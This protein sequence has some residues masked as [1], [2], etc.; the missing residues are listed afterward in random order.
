M[1]VNVKRIKQSER[2]RQTLDRLVTTRKIVERQQPKDY[3][4]CVVMKPWG[5][6]Y[7]I[8]EN[9]HVAIWFLKIKGRHST[10]MHCHPLKRTSLVLLSGKA[11]CNTLQHRNYLTSPAGLIIEKS[12]FHST[13]ALSS[14]G[15]ELIEIESPPNK[16]D[17]VRLNDTYGREYHGYEGFSEMETNDLKRFNYFHF[18]ESAEPKELSHFAEDYAI[19]F[20]TYTDDHQF[21]NDFRPDENEIVSP[22]RGQ[23]IDESGNPLL[24]AGEIQSGQTLKN[25]TK[26][27]TK[28]RLSL[29][30]IKGRSQKARS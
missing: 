13:K 7:L 15:I 8:F 11:F 9:E 21:Q 1:D 3:R 2:D 16:T 26:M 28:D 6:E 19:S 17:L 23:I 20:E 18:Q 30:R 29:L 5:Y 10:S 24:E 4:N 25:G 22:C 14:E 12:V 27:K